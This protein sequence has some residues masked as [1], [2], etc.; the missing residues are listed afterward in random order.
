MKKIIALALALVLAIMLVGCAAPKAPAADAPAAD[1]PAADAPAADASAAEGGLNMDKLYTVEVFSMTANY[2][3]IQPGW[4]AKVLKDKFNMEHNIVATNLEGGDSKLATMMASGDM[5]DLVIF[6]DNSTD[7]INNAIEAGLLLDWNENG[8]LETYGQTFLT[9]FPN[10]IEY[11]KKM[12]GNGEHVYGIGFNV[13]YNSDG[14]NE[15]KDLIWGPYVRYDLYEKVGSPKITKLEDWLPVLKQMQEMEPTSDTGKPTYGFSMWSDWDN[16][17]MMFAK[18]YGAM[19]GYNDLDNGNLLFIHAD[20]NKYESFLQDGGM[21]N[22]SLKLFFDANQMG[23]VDP[24]SISQK[25]A[26]VNAKISDGQVLFSYFSWVSGYNTPAHTDA[27]KGMYMVPFEEEAV[28]SYSLST[29]G[30]VR[31]TCIGSKA[32]DPARLMDFLNWVYSDEG[33]MVYNNGPEGMAWQFNADGKPELTEF[34]L[35]VY[36]DSTTEV[37][38]EWGGGAFNDGTPK[39]S[40]GTVSNVTVSKTFG[41]PFS[42]SLWESVQAFDTNPVLDNWR[43][44]IGYNNPKDYFVANDKIAIYKVPVIEG[45]ASIMSQDLEQKKAQIGSVVQEYSWRMVFAKDEAEFNA[46]WEEMT[47]KAY[48]LGYQELLDWSIAETEKIFAA[49]AA[50]NVG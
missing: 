32:E 11:N 4:F 43:G 45:G 8:L 12:F 21:Y 9:E 15:G 5:G 39:F 44:D 50:G 10:A 49:R 41:E 2:A 31:T 28:F 46:L 26:D 36:N 38:A 34:G 20:E 22:R 24:D 30:G 19:H 23:L 37:P 40:P 16:T 1:A 3:G 7:T 35:K 14:P 48:G 29:N 13:S 18:Q 27:G 17:H 47:D 42:W 6:G 25:N 33:T